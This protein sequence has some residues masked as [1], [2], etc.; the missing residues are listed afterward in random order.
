MFAQRIEVGGSGFREPETSASLSKSLRLEAEAASLQSYGLIPLPYLR[1]M[2]P[3]LC[4]VYAL[5]GLPYALSM[6]YVAFNPS[7]Y[8]QLFSLK[9]LD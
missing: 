5:C 7:T 6:V 1:P 9:P 2:W 3:S 8:T 4:P